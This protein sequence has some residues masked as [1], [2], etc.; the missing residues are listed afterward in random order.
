MTYN[1]NCVSSHSD[2]AEIF[3][4]YLYS[5]FS[6]NTDDSLAI[7]IDYQPDS[8]TLDE[9][10]F[11]NSDVLDLLTTLDDSKACGIDNYSPKIFK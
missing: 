1:S 8:P 7:D 5:V 11:S 2:K 10:H 6:A 3:N 9:I 4:N